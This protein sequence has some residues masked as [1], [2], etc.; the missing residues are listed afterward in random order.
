MTM[1]TPESRFDRFVDRRT[2]EAQH[3]SVHALVTTARGPLAS[4]LSGVGN[5]WTRRLYDGDFGLFDPPGDAPAISLVFVQSRE[6]N[7]AIANPAVLGGGPTDQHLIYEGLTRVAA[8]AVLA[9]AA[10][11]AGVNVFFSIW[12]PELVA[13]RRE[14]GLPR[15]PAQ[16][17]VSARGRIDVERGLLFNVPQV[18]VF[19]VAGRACLDRCAG[20]FAQRPWITVEPLEPDGLAAALVR[21]RGDHGIERISAI[22]GRSLASSLI[23]AGLVQ[24]LCLTT[25]TRSGGEPNT[26]FYTG[27][28]PPHLEL[29]VR[30]VGADPSYP[31]IVE[32][33][34]IR[35]A[36]TVDTQS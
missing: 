7:T 36:A 16:I 31:I 32:H 33:A 10:S 15:H 5:A 29:I 23:D 8:D 17:V 2:R 1:V 13:L 19:V 6:G 34:A 26:P 18:P 24:D 4:A 30:K 21:L 35:R 28:T 14:R 3:A 20:A 22:G 9:G 27:H 12:R 11:A 25:T